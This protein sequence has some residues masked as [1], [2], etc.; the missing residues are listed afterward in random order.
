[1]CTGGTIVGQKTVP[2]DKPDTAISSLLR[3][4]S[5]IACCDRFDRN[6]VMQD[7][8]HRTSNTHSAELIGNSWLTLSK[9]AQKSIHRN[10]HYIQRCIHGT[11]PIRIT[12]TL[13]DLSSKK[14]RLWNHTTKLYNSSEMNRHQMLEHWCYGN[15]SVI[16]SRGGRWT[17]Q[18][19]GEIGL[20]PATM[21]TPETK[22]PPKHRNTTL[23]HQA[24]T[25][26]RT[27]TVLFKK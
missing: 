4:P 6:C 19:W 11:H 8:Q 14:I 25:G 3:Q 18:N 5:T 13:P 12:G 27:S 9:A 7:K 20:S 26:D 23:K 22:K 1:M 24:E 2:C 21:E 15:Q 16:G 10:L 17:F